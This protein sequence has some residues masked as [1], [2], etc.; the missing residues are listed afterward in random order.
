MTILNRILSTYAG[1]RMPISHFQTSFDSHISRVTGTR[2]SEKYALYAQR[3]GEMESLVI[4]VARRGGRPTQ[5]MLDDIGA[6][7]VIDE[8]IEEI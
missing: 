4:S 7:I 8:Y 6:R 5:R 3:I 2:G 1:R